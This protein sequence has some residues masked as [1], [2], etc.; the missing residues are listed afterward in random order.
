MG[1]KIELE[2]YEKNLLKR[3]INDVLLPVLANDL[4]TFQR[5]LKKWDGKG[6]PPKQPISMVEM[7]CLKDIAR[8]L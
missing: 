8:I 6:K 1:I 7:D 3:C 5:K 4:R 2:D